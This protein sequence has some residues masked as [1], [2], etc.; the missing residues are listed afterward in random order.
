M[1]VVVLFIGEASCVGALSDR[2]V[3]VRKEQAEVLMLVVGWVQVRSVLG[4]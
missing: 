2:L 3:L 1:F 4:V